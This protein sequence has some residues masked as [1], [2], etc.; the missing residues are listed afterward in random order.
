MSR[1]E[2][3]YEKL[4]LRVLKIGIAIPGTIRKTYLICGKEN[5]RCAQSEDDRH[6]PYYF[7]NRK[8]RGKLTSKSL[9]SEQLHQYEHWISNRRQLESLV[10]EMITFGLNY[11]TLL[12]HDATVGKSRKTIPRKCGK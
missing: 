4:K 5:C 1:K 8:V 11:A 6:G 2:D 9:N 7:W 3:E 12:Q 10:E